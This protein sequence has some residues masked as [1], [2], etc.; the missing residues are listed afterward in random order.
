MT[1]RPPQAPTAGVAMTAIGVA[2][3]RARES[4]RPDRLYDDPWAQLFADA[5]RRGFAAEPDGEARWARLEALAEKFYEGRSVSVRLVD[6]V[7][8]AVAAGCRQLVT[9][10]V[11]F[12]PSA[13]RG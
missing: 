1:G 5:A 6:D 8:A 10:S 2:V 13:D 9:L 12:S 4:R 3:I 11:C 7:R